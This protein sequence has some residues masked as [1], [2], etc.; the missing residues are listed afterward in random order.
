M[1]HLNGL[2]AKNYGFTLIE[3]MLVISII[4]ILAAIAIP[5]YRDYIDES[6]AAEGPLLAKPVEVAVNNY[7]DRWGTLPADNTAAGLPSP[8]SLRGEWVASIEVSDGM[9]CV[10]YSDASRLKDDRGHFVLLPAIS[11]NYPTG[12]IL[13]IRNHED[14]PEDYSV[15]GDYINIT[16]ACV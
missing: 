4:G 14:I 13:W 12:A 7:Y 5:S 3:L 8:A 6:K 1:N 2:N 10:K 16:N 15:Q 9:I 11:T